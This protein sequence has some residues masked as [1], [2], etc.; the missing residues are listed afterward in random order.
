M[1]E[2]EAVVAAPSGVFS[3]FETFTAYS[4]ASREN[5]LSQL[6]AVLIK[7]IGEDFHSIKQLFLGAGIVWVDL[8]PNLGVYGM[9][10]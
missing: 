5:D 1:N 4:G 7:I 8:L 6:S 10:L 9:A 3:P 2:M